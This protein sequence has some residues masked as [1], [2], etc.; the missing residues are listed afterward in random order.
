MQ[1]TDEGDETLSL[2]GEADEVSIHDTVPLTFGLDGQKVF[3]NGRIA[4]PST[5]CDEHGIGEGTI[6]HTLVD[7][8]GRTFAAYDLK[9]DGN[10]RIRIPSRKRKLYDVEDGD[11]VHLTVTV[12][13]IGDG[14][15]DG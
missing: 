2:E 10:S 5:V 8:G 7:A 4:F 11:V 3:D 13:D 12:T 15:G 9:V 14:E 6:V 1:D